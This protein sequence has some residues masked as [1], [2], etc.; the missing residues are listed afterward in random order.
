MAKNTGNA[1]RDLIKYVRD[2]IKQQYSKANEC[3]ICSSNEDLELHHYHSVQLMVDEF[4]TINNLEEPKSEQECFAIRELIYKEKWFELVTD[5][6]T[7]CFTHHRELH[8]I[9]GVS[10]PLKT[11]EQQ[12]NWVIKRHDRF[13]NIIP[14]E[15]ETGRFSRFKTDSSTNFSRFKC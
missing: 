8:K 14:V 2:G 13:S 9:Y 3:A 7:L 11:T 10:P 12:R 15:K 1:K 4:L 5:T 6:V